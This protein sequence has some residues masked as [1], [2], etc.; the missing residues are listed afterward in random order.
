M[1]SD[2]EILP[3]L[4]LAQRDALGWS[5]AEDDRELLVS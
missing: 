3:Y 4:D 2:R 5:L 1:P